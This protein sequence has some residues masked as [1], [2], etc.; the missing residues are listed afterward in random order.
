M[1]NIL[2]N[3]A[4]KDDAALLSNIRTNAILAQKPGIWSAAEIERAAKFFDEQYLANEISS[5]QPF[6]IFNNLVSS[7]GFVSW[8]D[9]YLAY[10]FVA[11][12]GQNM[13]LGSRMLKYA[14]D[15]VQ[16][17]GHNK[18]WLWAHPYSEKFY[19]GKGYQKIPV[20]YAPFG[21]SLHKFEKQFQ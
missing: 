8:R 11:P 14:E 2:T 15:R 1:S 7:L 17:G 16:A 21:L 6:Y 4:G 13:G 9:D 12:E 20:T 10:L 19:L 3:L 18:I 5:G